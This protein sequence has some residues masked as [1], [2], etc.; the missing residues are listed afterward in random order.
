[1]TAEPSDCFILGIEGRSEINRSMIL[2]E[3]VSEMIPRL[4]IE[5]IIGLPEWE[6]L[7]KRDEALD[8]L[9]KAVDLAV[10]MHMNYKIFFRIHQ[11]EGV[12]TLPPRAG[13]GIDSVS[14]PV[15]GVNTILGGG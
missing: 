14:L 4:D 15:L 13:I 12:F 10:P 11:D 7:E 1:M 5:L 3:T 8:M 2:G 9:M 6:M